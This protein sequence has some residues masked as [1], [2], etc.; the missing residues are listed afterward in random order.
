[1]F[2]CHFHLLDDAHNIPALRFHLFYRLHVVSF[3][4][5]NLLYY[6]IKCTRY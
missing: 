2:L 3:D 1:M 5:I 4:G 6:R